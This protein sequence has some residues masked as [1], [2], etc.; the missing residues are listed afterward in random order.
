MMTEKQI[1]NLTSENAN[2]KMWL[3]RISDAPDMAEG[4]SGPAV[5]RVMA[6]CALAGADPS[7]TP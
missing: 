2:L 5:H 6:Q 1:Q 7:E 3:K 4:S